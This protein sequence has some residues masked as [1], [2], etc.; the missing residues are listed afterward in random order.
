MKTL[1]V[2]LNI[3]G[4]IWI[5]LFAIVFFL[6]IVGTFIAEPTLYLGWIRVTNMLSP[7][8]IVGWITA[9]VCLLPGIG[10]YKASEHFE[11]KRNTQISD[12]QTDSLRYS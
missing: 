5:G 6:G 3:L 9:F 2:L 1:S 12:R 11:K 7:F 8:N 4:H 10:F